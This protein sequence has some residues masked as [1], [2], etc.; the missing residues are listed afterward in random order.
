MW[1]GRPARELTR[2]MRVPL[3]E[4]FLEFFKLTTQAF[5]FDREPGNSLLQ[6][7]DLFR[8]IHA[9]VAMGG[10]ALGRLCQ[11]L[12]D[13]DFAAQQMRVPNFLLTCLPWQL[14]YQWLRVFRAECMQRIFDFIKP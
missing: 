7:R 2:K 3:L 5:D 10:P 4:L 13:V 9:R 1:H 14:G 8:L 6:L 12:L 11:H